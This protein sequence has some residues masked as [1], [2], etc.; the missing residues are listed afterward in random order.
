MKTKA[1]RRFVLL[2]RWVLVVSAT[3]LSRRAGLAVD[4]PGGVPRVVNA[5]IETRSAGAGLEREF[6]AIV[7]GQI[8]P[9]WVGYAVPM[10]AGQRQ[11][12]C[13]SSGG[14]FSRRGGCC[15][16]CQLEGSKEN[17]NVNSDDAP[18][19]RGPIKLE[20][21]DRLLVLFRV[22][23]KRVERIRTFSEECELDAG[24]LP[25][26]W[27]TEV[28]PRE[29]VA[30]L[31]GFATADAETKEGKRAMDHAVAAI[32]LHADSAA[33]RALEGLVAASRPERLRAH[34]AF[35]LGEARG[36]QGYTVLRRMAREDPSERV[37]EKVAFALSVSR[38]PEAVEEMI[39]TARSDSSVRVRGQALFWLAQK[40]GKKA[41]GAITEAIEDDP[42]TQVKKRAVFALSQLPK[43]EGVPLLIQVARTNRNPAVR[44]QAVFWLGQSH[45][46]RALAFF[47]E[48]LTH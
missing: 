33:D 48:V 5:W 13:Y 43:D 40:A 24:G 6:R 18:D 11:M 26:I 44:K 28:G 15:G 9:V 34:T 46:P 30:L 25:F 8:V 29:S 2:V 37:R 36:K 27:L 47:E 35:W 23:E 31:A 21:P 20:G 38:E 4:R 14:E 12:C 45:D 10:V 3:V 42:D 39:R 7:T 22:E 41:A 17:F 16:Q 19:S 32:A 1:G